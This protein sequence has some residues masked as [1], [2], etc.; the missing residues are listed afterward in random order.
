MQAI[1][2]QVENQGWSRSFTLNGI[3]GFFNYG[4]EKIEEVDPE[5]KLI[6]QRIFSDCNDLF[7]QPYENIKAEN[8]RLLNEEL[9]NLGSEPKIDNT[10]MK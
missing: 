1:S 2:H 5:K 9:N 8:E 10:K 6:I 3:G 4:S 7:R